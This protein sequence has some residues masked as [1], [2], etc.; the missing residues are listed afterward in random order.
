MSSSNPAEGAYKIAFTQ[1]RMRL[2]TLNPSEIVNR[3]LCKFDET[4]N[5]F[6]LESFGKEIAISYP[7]GKVRFF[8]TDTQLPM[9]WSLILLNY[10]SSAKELPLANQP[11]SYRELPLGN[12]FFPNI[13][14][15]VLLVL[16]EFYT[17][18]DKR[19]LLEVLGKI[20]FAQVES[21]ADLAADG[22]FAPRVPVMIR[23]WEGEDEIPSSC[24]ILFDRTVSEQMHIEDIAALCSLI[25]HLILNLYQTETK[26]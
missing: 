20:G 10:L 12:V 25:K 7:D 17:K 16:G 23:F 24:Q 2:Q 6:Y 3:S 22:S 11:A 9:G 14:T 26:F 19:M 1:S 4:R 5:S 21:K 8:G 18:C 13:K 15:H